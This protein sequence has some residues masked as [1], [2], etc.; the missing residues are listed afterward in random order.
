[1]SITV[2]Q[3]TRSLQQLFNRMVAS[4]TTG[5]KLPKFALLAGAGCSISSGVVSGSRI[6]DIL[7]KYTY[8]K[9]SVEKTEKKHST[10]KFRDAPSEI[11]FLLSLSFLNTKSILRSM[12]IGHT[13][14][15]RKT[16]L[17]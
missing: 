14:S 1:M 9:F 16:Y 6:I 11:S 5:D 3:K 10:V 15:I 13:I 17:F 12:R 7:Q 8:L 2:E 4:K